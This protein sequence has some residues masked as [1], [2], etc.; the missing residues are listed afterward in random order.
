METDGVLGFR[1][2]SVCMDKLRGKAMYCV[3]IL[4]TAILEIYREYTEIGAKMVKSP[5]DMAK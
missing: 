2:T 3:A 5:E 1:V 4:E